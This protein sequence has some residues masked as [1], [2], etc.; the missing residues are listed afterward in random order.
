[1]NENANALPAEVKA[2]IE[3]LTTSMSSTQT[4]MAESA[5]C[6]AILAYGDQRAREAA[7][8]NP[9]RDAVLNACVLLE[10]VPPDDMSPRD[11]LNQ[12]LAQEQAIVLDPRVSSDAANLQREAA[13]QMRE[14]CA[15][16]AESVR[17]DG[18]STEFGRGWSDA[19]EIAAYAIRALPLEGD[20]H[21]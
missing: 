13:K 18:E 1:M 4:R 16:E 17:F 19:K 6:A 5:L 3:A 9:W 21:A 7:E 14:R 11:V 12:V 2:H 8:H 20:D 10:W 15:L